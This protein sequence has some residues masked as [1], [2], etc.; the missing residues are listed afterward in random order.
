MM[1]L[2]LATA[3]L[4][5]QPVLDSDV[6]DYRPATSLKG[7]LSFGPTDGYEKLLELWARRLKSYHPDLSGPDLLRTAA[8]ETPQVMALG[9]ARCGMLSRRWTGRE[10]ESFRE[11]TGG[12]PVE[13]IVGADAV[14]IIVHPDNPLRALKLEEIDAIFSSTLNRG[15]HALQTWGEFKLGAAWVGKPIHAYGMA[16]D[17]T[18]ASHA[19]DVFLHQA[20]Q[21]GKLREDLKTLSS[22]AAVVQSVAED[23]LGIGFVPY[24]AGT[25]GVRAVPILSTDSKP[26]ELSWSNLQDGTYPLLWQI[27]LSYRCDRGDALDPALHEFLALVLSRDGQ[28][29]LAEEGYAPISGPLARKQVKLL[30]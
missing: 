17:A 30:K 18:P 9:N 13:L 21:R 28:T 16:A 6:P 4:A 26:I 3:L 8:L 20:L 27:R 7:T 5:A 2:S 25:K 19:R 1:M 23:P 29:I 24:S 10:V 15:S 12:P 11:S 14:A 22:A